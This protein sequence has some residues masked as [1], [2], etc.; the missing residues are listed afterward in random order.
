MTLTPGGT[1]TRDS[2][3]RSPALYPL[4]Y[5]G[6]YVSTW[7]G[8]MLVEIKIQNRTQ[9]VAYAI[10]AK[11]ISKALLDN[12]PILYMHNRSQYV[13]YASDAKRVSKA[14]C[15]C[16]QI[17]PPQPQPCTGRGGDLGTTALPITKDALKVVGFDG[18]GRNSM[19]FHVDINVKRNAITVKGLKQ[20]IFNRWVEE[21]GTV[22][23]GPR[24]GSPIKITLYTGPH[25]VIATDDLVMADWQIAGVAP[26][27]TIST[28]TPSSADVTGG[29]VT[30]D[31]NSKHGLLIV[32]DSGWTPGAASKYDPPTQEM[33]YRERKHV[34]G[35]T[36]DNTDLSLT[37]VGQRY[38]D[39]DPGNGQ[40]R[41]NAYRDNVWAGALVYT[42]CD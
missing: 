21:D 37:S 8:R 13:A 5:G 1:R 33:M 25:G 26:G 28:L 16:V 3:I 19:M 30:L 7:R 15:C 11:R 35:F 22:S 20:Y 27:V 39:N 18:G 24:E 29:G 23:G 9:Y 17:T 10:D 38:F 41:G 40:S 34:T 31:A 12:I 36:T 4:S 32:L 42:V 14:R 2:W 6:V